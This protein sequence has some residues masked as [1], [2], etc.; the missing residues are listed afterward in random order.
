MAAEKRD[1]SIAMPIPSTVMYPIG[2]VHQRLPLRGDC[3]KYSLIVF[4][5][6]L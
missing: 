4:I 6:M 5:V 3:Y 2:E 1:R